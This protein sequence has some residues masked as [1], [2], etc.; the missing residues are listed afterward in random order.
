ML[1]IRDS[2]EVAG[3]PSGGKEPRPLGASSAL[4]S[5]DILPAPHSVEPLAYTEREACEALRVSKVTL[6]RWRQRGLI[7]TIPGIRINLYPVEALRRFVN[8][9]GA[10]S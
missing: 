4:R 9:G 6:W 5:Q 8:N 10:A 3:N 1:T 2:S 7:Q